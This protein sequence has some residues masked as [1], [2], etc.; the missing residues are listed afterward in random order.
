AH[1][2][3][4]IEG[5][6]VDFSSLMT[7]EEAVLKVGSLNAGTLMT[8]VVSTGGSGDL[9]LDE[10]GFL[11]ITAKEGVKVGQIASGGNIEIFAGNDIY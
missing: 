7:G 1:G 9:V 2:K 6:A 4:N 5:G 8:G 3:A 10:K 11:L